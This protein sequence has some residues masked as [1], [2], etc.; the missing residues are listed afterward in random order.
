MTNIDI[1]APTGPSPA[2]LARPDPDRHGPGP[3]PAVV[4][5]HDITGIGIDLHSQIERITD[6][7][8]VVLAPDLFAA[9]K[10][11]TCIAR[12]MRDL[13]R[14]HG[15]TIETI[16]AAQT[17]LR[18]DAGCTDSIGVIGF[19]LGGGFA[20][21]TAARGFDAAAP[22]YGQIPIGQHSELRGA[23]PIVASFGRRDPTLPGA[24][25][26]LQR[27]LDEHEIEHDIK[28]YPGVG[29]SFA[30]RIDLGTATPLLKVTGFA[31]DDA[32][33][34]DAWNRVAAFF[35]HHLRHLP[36]LE[37]LDQPRDGHL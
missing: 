6:L 37:P 23:C 25:K 7:G 18:S 13:V 26:R 27:S 20:L 34:E 32:A 4:V 9:G 14:R 21:L 12:A 3:Y 28:T 10:R 24:G 8:Y 5:L 36:Q 16:L 11:P 29:H 31:F 15:P 1:P 17:W 2:I 33:T 30:N 35:D 22:F 19:C